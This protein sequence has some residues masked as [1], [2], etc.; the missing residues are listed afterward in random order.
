MSEPEPTLLS[1]ALEMRSAIDTLENAMMGLGD[2]VELPRIY[3]G[4]PDALILAPKLL[5][6]EARRVCAALSECTRII[7]A[8]EFA[9][10]ALAALAQDE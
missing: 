6:F 2:F 1:R 8:D 3:E 7:N 4:S 10:G 5:L 9:P